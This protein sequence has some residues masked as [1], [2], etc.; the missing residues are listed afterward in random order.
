MCYGHTFNLV[1]VLLHAFYC[2]KGIFGPTLC[3]SGV[4]TIGYFKKN[5]GVIIYHYTINSL[6]RFDTKSYLQ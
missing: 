5:G 2:L 4:I 3:V 1:C 6:D